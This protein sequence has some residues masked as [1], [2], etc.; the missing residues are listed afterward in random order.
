MANDMGVIREFIY[1]NTIFFTQAS[2]TKHLCTVC[3]KSFN[4]RKLLI[5]HIRTFHDEN[6]NKCPECD[7][8]CRS[9]S[10]LIIHQRVHTKE[11]PH[12]C[13]F[14]EKSFSQVSHLNEH[15]N[16]LHN[17]LQNKS[18]RSQ[19]IC[20]ICGLVLSSK[21]AVQRHM[22]IHL[23]NE[24]IIEQP[25]I[26]VEE[27]VD[28]MQQNVLESISEIPEENENYDTN[29]KYICDFENCGK[30]LKTYTSLKLHKSTHS[31]NFK[32]RRPFSCETCFKSFT[33]KSHLTVHLRIHSGAKPHMCSVCGKQFSVRS[34]MRKHLKMH[35]KQNKND[36]ND[37]LQAFNQGFN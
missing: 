25:L 17:N 7:R 26:V 5:R 33:Q 28:V 21:G 9:K 20:E 18:N 37:F 22:Q 2:A 31:S 16:A 24:D 3:N 14:C 29:K 36:E 34:N 10:E 12:E 30:I 32:E 19:N 11:K 13:Q 6:P 35:E 23:K 27:T 1:N 15:I 4:L 8:L